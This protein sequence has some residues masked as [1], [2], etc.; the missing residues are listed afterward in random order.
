[1]KRYSEIPLAQ[2]DRDPAQPRRLFDDV[3]LEALA[4]SIRQ[5]GVLQP[6]EVSAQENGR[7]L[8]HHGERR[9]RAAKLA[10]LTTIPAIIAPPP[11]TDVERL[12]RGMVEN[13]L[14]ED[15]P[16]IDEARGYQR[17]RD[18]GMTLTEMARRVGRSHPHIVGRLK[19]LEIDDDAILD[20]VNQG[21]LP[22]DRRA[23]EALMTIKEPATR[24]K[25]AQSLAQ[26]GTSL[27][28][29][30]SAVNH[31]VGRLEKERIAGLQARDVKIPSLTIAV[32]G[33]GPAAN[34]PIP[35]QVIRATAKSS[36][37]HCA[38]FENVGMQEP[39]WSLVTD[40]AAKICQGCPS[41]VPGDALDVCRECPMV[42]LLTGLVKATRDARR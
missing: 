15:L 11:A 22:V 29:V 23:A 19:W 4:E 12:V 20:L 10:G 38:Y 14:R 8:L 2:I 31:L 24:R 25:M 42:H 37:A 1:M 5:D 7:F 21:K 6:V 34:A 9:W 30:I 26:N 17:L 33:S 41:Y 27:K 16:P 36:C 39:A 13:M 3:T 40:T 28:G 32:N 35:L 18:A